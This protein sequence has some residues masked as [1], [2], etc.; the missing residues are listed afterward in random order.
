VTP[1]APEVFGFYELL[2]ILLILI[3]LIGFVLILRRVGR[4]ESERH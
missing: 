4:H 1:T 2:A 3:A